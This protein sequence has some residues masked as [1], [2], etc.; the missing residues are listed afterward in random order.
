MYK[1]L[2]L[3]KAEMRQWLLDDMKVSNEK[4]DNILHVSEGSVQA[5]R[6][7]IE[8][9]EDD[10]HDVLN[11]WLE[12]ITKADFEGMLNFSLQINALG[13]EAQKLVF[14]NALSMLRGSL[15]EDAPSNVIFAR[16]QD[17]LRL[18]FVTELSTVLNDVLEGIERNAHVQALLMS[19]S[20]GLWKWTKRNMV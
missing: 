6:T 16:Y 5:A 13:K 8:M 11:Q 9:S 12:V 15:S 10:V 3:S 4:V 1:L 17:H 14:R 18:D 19:K 7:M 20:I 2:P